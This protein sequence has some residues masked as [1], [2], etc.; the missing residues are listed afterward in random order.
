MESGIY[1]KS[2]AATIFIA[3]LI[4]VGVLLI[5]L[6]I[7]LT[8]M[9]QSCESRNTGIVEISKLNDNYNYC[10]IFSLHAGSMLNRL[11]VNDFHK[12]C[13]ITV[14]QYIK[15]GQYAR[16]LNFT[17]WVAE[18]FFNDV[19]PLEDGLNLVLMDTD[20]FFPSSFHYTDPFK[21]R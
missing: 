12:I 1:I 17:V 11:D 15:E 4:T 20:D 18:S 7:A 5:T 14:V 13:K 2:F 19:K 21:S 16:D 10:N 9:L 6:L 8:A 3:G